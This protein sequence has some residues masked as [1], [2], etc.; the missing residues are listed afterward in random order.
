MSPDIR[1]KQIAVGSKAV[2]NFFENSFFGGNSLPNI[3][4]LMVVY[5]LRALEDKLLQSLDARL[6]PSSLSHFVSVHQIIKNS[7]L[8]SLAEHTAPIILA[9]GRMVI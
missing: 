1:K 8:M 3:K 2:Q 9:T 5:H 6:V 7:H 4:T